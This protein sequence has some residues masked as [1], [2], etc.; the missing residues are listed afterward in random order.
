MIKLAT[1]ISHL[2][3]DEAVGK[4]IFAKSDCLECREE[5]IRS[6]WPKQYIFHFDKNIVHP[7][8]AEE[9]GF[10]S[11]AILAKKELK[12]ATFHILSSSSRPLLKEY[13]FYCGGRQFSREEMLDNAHHNADWL[14]TFI[15]NR[16]IGIALENI[17]YY[18]TPAYQHV[19]ETHF[20]N[21]IIRGNG[22]SFIFDLAH[23]RIT[24]YNKN[25]DYRS[26]I[27]ELPMDKMVQLH[28][29]RHRINE[30][31]LAYDAHEEVEDADLEEAR[32]I[33]RK[34]SPEYLT[35]EYYRDKDKLIQTLK[36]C[37]KLCR[38][39]ERAKV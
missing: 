10:I 16:D 32:D 23:A 33:M 14:K 13:V 19:T 2:F 24:A 6:A 30:K 12:L 9:K 25:E 7:W 39:A 15:G 36:Q 34:F 5:R 20:I 37:K 26:Y 28:V 27:S 35:V 8:G 18:P 17:N 3:E 4:E 1:P 21:E 22:L 11:A 29:S 31:G 38:E